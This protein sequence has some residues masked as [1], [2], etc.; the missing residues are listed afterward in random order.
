MQKPFVNYTMKDKPTEDSQ[1]LL[2]PDKEVPFT[3][4]DPW[5]VMRIMSEFVQGFD[6]LAELSR[7]V[8][9]FGSAR[10]KPG[11][12]NYEAAV[13]TAFLLGE[14]GCAIITGGGPGIMEAANKGAQQAGVLSVGLNIE[15]PFE[16]H[17]NPYVDLELNHR[18]FFVRKTM[19]VKYAQA[20][21]IFPGGFG[22]MDELFESLT[23]IQTGKISNFP[24]VLFDSSYWRGLLDWLENSMKHGGK[25]EAA[26][27]D[28]LLLT[29]SPEEVRNFIMAS[30]EDGGEQLVRETAAKEVTRKA[31][32]N[33]P[34]N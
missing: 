14:A 19:L 1:L 29:D 22:T 30:L 6:A 3:E 25:I 24:I 2:A 9:I 31:F 8:T 7:A 13:E 20:F 33:Q 10:T 16:Q 23:L 28:L 34:E 17:I 27:L 12:P 15:L 11:D 32:S 26:D 18:Y 4:T 21:V 5:R